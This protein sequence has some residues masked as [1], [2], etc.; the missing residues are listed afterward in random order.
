MGGL[1]EVPPPVSSSEPTTSTAT[2]DGP[3]ALSPGSAWRE[4]KS[5]IKSAVRPSLP[6]LAGA[7]VARTGVRVEPSES[8]TRK[9][10]ASRL[11]AAIGHANTTGIPS[12]AFSAS[13]P[14]WPAQISASVSGVGALVSAV[15]SAVV[16]TRQ[17]A[18]SASSASVP[19]PFA[20]AMPRQ[21]SYP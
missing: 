5:P 12:S 3:S 20:S 15:P 4:P 19:S 8:V 21:S 13:G 9:S 14:A 6:S 7:V 16:T 10:L 17:P 18:V 11:P 2:G 1:D